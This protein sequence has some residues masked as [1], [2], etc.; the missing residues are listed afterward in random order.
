LY[1][2]S[3]ISLPAKVVQAKGPRQTDDEAFKEYVEK[4]GLPFI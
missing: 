4:Y 3:G 2:G 1:E